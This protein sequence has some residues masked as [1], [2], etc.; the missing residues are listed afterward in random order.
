MYTDHV[1]NTEDVLNVYRWDGK[2]TSPETGVNYPA[3]FDEP[4]NGS[5]LR[6]VT[7]ETINFSKKHP[8]NI[9]FFSTKYLG[10]LQIT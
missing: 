4:L 8:L 3:I 10:K 1:H 6:R 2:L 5:W 9:V 7:L